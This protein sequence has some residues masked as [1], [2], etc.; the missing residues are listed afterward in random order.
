MSQ[1]KGLAPALGAVNALLQSQELAQAL[2][3]HMAKVR[4]AEVVGPQVAGVTQVERVQNGTELVVRV[5]NSVWA[6]ELVLLKG[7]MLRRLNQTLGGKVLTDIHFKASGL[8]R[9]KKALERPIPVAPDAPLEEE[10]ARIALSPNA[11]LRIEAAVSG[12]AQPEWRE[13]IRRTLTR[14]ACTEQWKREHGWR[15]CVRCGSLAVLTLLHADALHLCP[16][17]RAG[18]GG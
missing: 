3:P 8:S 14:A 16:L 10:L 17:C 11:L 4:W 12:I 15:P 1:K 5:K 2:R 6:N 7:D 18:V 9:A 13:R